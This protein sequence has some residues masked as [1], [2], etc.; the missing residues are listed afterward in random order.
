[1]GREYI[2]AANARVQAQDYPIFLFCKLAMFNV[3]P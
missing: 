1:M 2:P 3:R